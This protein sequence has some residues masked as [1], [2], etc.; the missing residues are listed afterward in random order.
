M[1]Y[2]PTSCRIIDL[3]ICL[4]DD[5]LIDVHSHLLPGI[6]DG[7]SSLE[8][9]LDLARAAVKDG[10]THALMTPHH[11]NGQYTNHAQ[12]V[13]DRTDA[14]Q[15]ALDEAKIPLTV[16]PCQEVH[17]SGDLISAI[18]HD[19]ILTTDEDGTYML[20]EFP[21]DAIPTYASDMIFQVMQH[22]ITPII[23]HPERNEWF[24]KH[25]E[26]LYDLITRGCVSQVTAS[27]YVGTFGKNVQAF[28]DDIVSHGLAHV[29][30]S[31]AHH[32]HNR[33]YEMTAAFT[34]LRKEMDL[35]TADIFEENAKAIVNGDPIQRFLQVPIKKKRFFAK[36]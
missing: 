10:I 7:S 32:M 35:E 15:S 28:A 26:L 3:L 16:F 25:P 27:S 8:H 36:Y 30:A 5:P 9:S 17:I 1:P 19:D 31:D 20:L 29:F 6:D 34:R 33:D 12:D 2:S 11:M 23:V 4:E 21:H 13:I 22:G 18:E 14:F 24:M